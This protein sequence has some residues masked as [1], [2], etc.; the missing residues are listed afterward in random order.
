MNLV[1][2]GRESVSVAALQA[3]AVFSPPPLLNVATWADEFR[4]LST[5]D[6]AEPGQW[7]TARA[8]YQRD[9]MNA[10]NDPGIETIVIMSSAQVGKT[11]I[12]NNILGYLIDQDPCPIMFVAPTAE[13]AKEWSKD[14]FMEGM[15]NVTPCLRGKVIEERTG[16]GAKSTIQHRSFPGGYL[17]VA[18]AGSPSRLASRPIRVVLLDE[19][20]KYEIHTKQGDPIERAMKRTT[21]FWNRKHV[22]NSTPTLKDF[23]AVEKWYAKS[24][25]RRFYVPCP[26]CKEFGVVGFFPDDDAQFFLQWPKE[27]NSRG[28]VVKHEWEKAHLVCKKC[29][30]VVEETHKDSMVANGKWV[31]ENPGGNVAGFQ[32]NELISA[33]SSWPSIAKRFVDA[34]GDNESLRMF[35]NE[36][37]GRTWE[38]KG[39]A[40]ND[41]LL[42]KRRERYAEE[43]PAGA[44]VLTAGADVQ[45]DRIEVV[46]KGWG[47]R[48][49]ESWGITHKIIFG[50][51]KNPDTWKELDEFLAKKFKHECGV[52]LPI[53][54]TFIDAG[55]ETQ[56]VYDFCKRRS[57]RWI[58]PSIGR[59]EPRYIVTRPKNPKDGVYLW[60]VGT[61]I[62]KEHIYRA[63][64]TEAPNAGETAQPG[65]CHYPDKDEFDLE[66]FAQLTAEKMVL[67]GKS[68]SPRKE[69]QKIR[70]R[71]EALDME[72]Y[73]LGALES[74]RIDLVKAHAS[75]MAKAHKLEHPPEPEPVIAG[76]PQPEVQKPSVPKRRPVYRNT[77]VTR[78]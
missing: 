15:V 57:R 33:W 23:S 11:Q 3:S 56:K 9:I 41:S 20:D 65:F 68:Y 12:L 48:A 4:K 62:A 25:Q 43:V 74:R 47:P 21:T 67:V 45:A 53:A 7:S 5:I 46:V 1:S 58:F 70:A 24:D 54:A 32:L 8:A 6:S 36:T 69:W 61:D 18:H 50:S 44:A 37:L 13:D 42:F 76:A 28:D 38:I 49:R 19:L 29:G 17:V 73:A 60:M 63:L 39:E 35:Y 10:F 51:P 66:Y 16:K 2:Q 78:W 71:N 77:F 59:S 34:T 26:E 75:L 22:I 40:I 55:Y 64:A 31:A 72:V 14:R 30:G 52:E 27:K